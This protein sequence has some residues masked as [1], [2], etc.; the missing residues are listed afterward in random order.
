MGSFVLGLQG[1]SNET[2][3]PNG[4]STFTTCL[5]HPF[6]ST[7]ARAR[8]AV[9][10]VLFGMTWPNNTQPCSECPL[11]ANATLLM[12]RRACHCDI[13]HYGPSCGLCRP[14]WDPATCDGS[15]CAVGYVSGVPA[16]FIGGSTPLVFNCSTCDTAAGFCRTS[17]VGANGAFCAPCADCAAPGGT[18]S[19]VGTV[20]ATCVCNPGFRGPLC[21]QCFPRFTGALCDQ[22]APGYVSSVPGATETCDACDTGFCHGAFS[23]PDPDPTNDQFVNMTLGI[24]QW[25]GH[26]TSPAFDGTGDN[27]A[28]DIFRM[29]PDPWVS[30][31]APCAECDPFYGAV[32]NQTCMC[33]QVEIPD[34]PGR[35]YSNGNNYSSA[36]GAC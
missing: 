18:A 29:L 8:C 11:N 26:A 28:L 36:I 17:W 1:V 24:Q 13:F 5:A 19:E 32:E 4:K 23:N 22:C 6:C 10:A 15:A 14:E 31:C 20:N 3:A 9:P 33:R 7:D 2:N 25:E 16:P 30:Q 34:Y 12:D 35:D 21:D 27:V